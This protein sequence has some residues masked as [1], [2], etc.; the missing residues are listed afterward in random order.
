MRILDGMQHNLWYFGVIPENVEGI[1]GAK[2][3]GLGCA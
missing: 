3:W 1:L 2:K